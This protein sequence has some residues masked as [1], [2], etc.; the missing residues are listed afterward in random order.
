MTIA[1]QWRRAQAGWPRR[2]PLVQ[3]PNP[4]LLVAF[5]GRRVAAAARPGDRAERLGRLAS[6]LGFGV[7]AWGET[8]RGANWFRRLLGLLGLVW[9]ARRRIR[10]H[11]AS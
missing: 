10:G 8:T 7:W 2:F 11:A 5:A 3:A 4:P 1:E 9:I 6:S